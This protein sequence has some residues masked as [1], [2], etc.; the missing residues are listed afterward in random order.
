MKKLY[1]LFVLLLTSVGMWAQSFEVDGIKYSVVSATDLTVKVT[2]YNSDYEGDLVIN[3]TVSYNDTDYKIISIVGGTWTN[4]PFHDC[5]KLIRIG[6]LPYCTEIESYAFFN[7]DNLVSVGDLSAC[8]TIG[9]SIFEKCDGLVS[10]GD[11]SACMSI[12][13]GV[14][15]NCGSLTTV[16]NMS[17]CTSIGQDAFNDCSSLTSVGDLSSCTTLGQR[18]FQRCSSLTSVDLS[19]CTSI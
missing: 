6:D 5:N 10:V 11:L 9:N 1:L 14:F 19:S 17:S 7:C 2:G 16:G 18:A 3:G 8:T 15:W 13:P 4:S 12:P